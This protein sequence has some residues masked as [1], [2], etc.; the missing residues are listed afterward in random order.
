MEMEKCSCLHT[1]RDGPTGTARPLE[2][3]PRRGREAPASLW[4]GLSAGCRSRCDGRGSPSPT[5]LISTLCA[6]SLLRF[7]YRRI[8]F[9]PQI[10]TPNNLNKYERYYWTRQISFSFS[11]RLGWALGWVVY[12]AQRLRLQYGSISHPQKITSNVERGRTQQ[13]K[14]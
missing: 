11:F 12:T 7:C 14:Q 9:A 3:C 8:I 1:Y 6:H 2:V 4:S 10:N 5:L 13:I